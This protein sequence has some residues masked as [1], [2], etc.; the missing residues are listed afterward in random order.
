M[1]KVLIIDDETDICFLISEILGDEKFICETA[2]N[3]NESLSKFNKFNP[4]IIILDVWLGNS[5]I[6]G[7]ELLSEFKSLNPLVPVIIISGH[8]TVD[9]A[10]NAIKKGA[11]DFIETK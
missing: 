7:L 3:S 11:Y 9:M 8:G 5:D 10:V 2:N 6:D 1:Y 4:D